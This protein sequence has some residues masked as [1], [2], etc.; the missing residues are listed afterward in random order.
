MISFFFFTRLLSVYI[1]QS[2]LFDLPIK[3]L[4]LFALIFYSIF[5]VR[6][7]LLSHSDLCILLWISYALL[8]CRQFHFLLF[9]ALKQFSAIYLI[10]GSRWYRWFYDGTSI[11]G[12]AIMKICSF[13]TMKSA[14]INSERI[15][16][17][18]P[19]IFFE[20]Q[21]KL[22]ITGTSCTIAIYN[23]KWI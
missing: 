16:Y 15:N 21:D 22:R 23:G 19:I 13:M 11:T 18:I 14:T 2:L 6:W 7:W 20:L 9:W 3:F 4:L 17:I 12:E 1:P 5:V 10:E 8:C